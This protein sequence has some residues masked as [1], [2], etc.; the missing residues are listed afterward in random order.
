LNVQAVSSLRRKNAANNRKKGSKSPSLSYSCELG[1][2]SEFYP[3]AIIA[4]A[5][6]PAPSDSTPCPYAANSST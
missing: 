5:A 2:E 3:D 1:L 6:A 4:A